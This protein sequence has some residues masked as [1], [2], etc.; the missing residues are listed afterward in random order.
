MLMKG[1]NYNLELIRMVGAAAWDTDVKA[2][3]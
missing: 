3:R 2:G 1:K